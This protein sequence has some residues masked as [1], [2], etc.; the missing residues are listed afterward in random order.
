M[1][2]KP[3]N[4]FCRLILP[5]ENFKNPKT[6]FGQSIVKTTTIYMKIWL[7]F[8]MHIN[9]RIFNILEIYLNTKASNL[10]LYGCL[11][12]ILDLFEKIWKNPA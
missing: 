3:Q 11:L 12:V 10:N 6:F 5:K 4:C 1:T 2:E 7:S 9:T 8:I